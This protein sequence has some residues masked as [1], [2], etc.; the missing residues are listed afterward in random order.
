[1]IFR[2]SKITAYCCIPMPCC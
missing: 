2:T 1:M